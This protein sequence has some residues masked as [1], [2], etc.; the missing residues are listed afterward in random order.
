[1]DSIAATVLVLSDTHGEALQRPVTTSADVAIHCGDITEESKL[2]EFRA[3]I[4]MLKTIDAPVKLVIAGNHDF[5]LDDKAFSNTRREIS[6][7]IDGPAL[8]RTYGDLGEARALF[9]AEEPRAAGITFLDEGIHRIPLANGA[10]MT[11]Y[12]SPYT[13]S[14]SSGWGFQYDPSQE[15]H[16][17]TL[18]NTV[19]LAMTHSPP[20]GIFDY[21]A[22]K[23]R[24]GSQGLFAAIAKAK[25][26][27]HCFGHIHESWG[28][29][30]VQWRP[31]LS[32]EPSHFT[33]I[34]NDGSRLIESRATLDNGRFDDEATLESKATKRAVLAAQGYCKIDTA[35]L[36]KE[37]TLFVNAAIECVEEG[38][39]HLPWLLEMQLPRNKDA[40]Y[41]LG[42]A[43]N[44]ARLI[45]EQASAADIAHS[46]KE[47]SLV[48]RPK[49]KRGADALN[50]DDLTAG[51]ISPR[52]TPSKVTSRTQWRKPAKRRA[53]S[54]N[55]K[56]S[57]SVDT[58]SQM[59]G[60]R[61]RSTAGVRKHQRYPALR[62]KR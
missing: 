29:K 24:A 12:A 51:E 45:G 54:T 61:R 30:L 60:S 14:K 26:K 5:T 58:E 31:E 3:A 42:E 56:S 1:M 13:P 57:P 44:A 23:T 39:Q 40:S 33:D 28:A 41:G 62:S 8:K 16:D 49:G 18:D 25:P 27:V 59:G 52:R 47:L 43:D 48:I 34:D 10:L 17:W 19:D 38:T 20:H 2:D 50:E 7:T 35:I 55:L 53:V 37:Q 15:Q 4:T 32:D 11:V 9:D 46:E 6:S 22:S 21:T 36:D